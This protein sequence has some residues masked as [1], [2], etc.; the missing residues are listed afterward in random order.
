LF[1]A[2]DHLRIGERLYMIGKPKSKL[3]ASMTPT[4]QATKEM[5]TSPYHHDKRNEEAGDAIKLPIN[6]EDKSTILLNVEGA[7]KDLATALAKKQEIKGV[8]VDEEITSK[9]PNSLT[10]VMVH[11][12]CKGIREDFGIGFAED[13]VSLKQRGSG[14][15]YDRKVAGKKRLLTREQK[16]ELLAKTQMSYYEKDIA[17][18]AMTLEQAMFA[19]KDAFERKQNFEEMGYVLPAK[20]TEYPYWVDEAGE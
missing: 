5:P 7:V 20:K 19:L 3:P 16:N 8:E 11:Y 2:P 9:L 10:G 13:P 6:K 18:G 12:F 15:A 1:D 17:A 14:S 4:T